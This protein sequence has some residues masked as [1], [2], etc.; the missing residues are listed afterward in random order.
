[1]NF[2][3][4]FNYPVQDDG[5]EPEDYI[6]LQDWTN[7]DWGK[8]LKHT[9]TLIFKAGQTIIHEGDATQA[10]FIVSFGTLEVIVTHG[11]QSKRIAV[12][13]AGSVMG[14]QSF[15]DGKPRSADI[16]ASSECQIL[17]LSRERFDIFAARE[18]SLARDFLFDL[19]RILSLRLRHAHDHLL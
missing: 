9:Q 14:E 12:I 13:Q 5:E 3:S 15:L 18:P 2:S 6:F 11:R 17:Q 4:F 19:G 7:E 8:L 16:R 1:M 10:L